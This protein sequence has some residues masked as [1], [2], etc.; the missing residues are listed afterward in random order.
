M[1]K[2]KRSECVLCGASGHEITKEHHPTKSLIINK[3]YNNYLVMPTCKHCNNSLSFNEEVL[4]DLIEYYKYHYFNEKINN[5]ILHSIDRNK[6]IK[7]IID[8]FFE[9]NQRLRVKT[10]LLYP[11]LIK[12]SKIHNYICHEYYNDKA[13]YS[14]INMK[15]ID[16]MSRDDINKFFS[17]VSIE[18]D[19]E[20]R[21]I[22]YFDTMIEN[23]NKINYL[24]SNYYF[25]KD[26][27]YKTFNKMIPGEYEFILFPDT[28][29]E[30]AMHF[31]L[32]LK[33]IIFCEIL[34]K[35]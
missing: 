33:N 2:N 28:D 31:K 3:I 18:Y 1:Y 13:T 27:V 14:I 25:T 30:N 26:G 9:N 7:C 8:D 10:E 15:F 16:E 35:N 4:V 11:V 21:Q 23:G 6:K 19:N 5:K 34:I 22:D 32:N 24:A 17:P 20:E 29:I 12:Y